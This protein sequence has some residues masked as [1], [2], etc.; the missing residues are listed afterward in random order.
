MFLSE[1]CR[2]PHPPSA[3]L[4]LLAY[5]FLTFRYFFFSL[6]DSHPADCLLGVT[7]SSPLPSPACLL[8]AILY[9]HLTL[10]PN[11]IYDSLGILLTCSSDSKP[12]AQLL[13]YHTSL[14]VK[15]QI[16]SFYATPFRKIQLPLSS[17]IEASL[18]RIAT[19]VTGVQHSDGTTQPYADAILEPR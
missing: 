6:M 18:T 10:L 14:H 16:I 3:F 12:E 2:S 15:E 7:H 19:L 1:T 8:I 13:S 11:L 17:F 5:V 9:Q 4:N